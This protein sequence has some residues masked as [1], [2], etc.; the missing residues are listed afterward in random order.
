MLF[1][2][3]L[4]VIVVIEFRLLQSTHI[5]DLN[6]LPELVANEESI[7]SNIFPSNGSFGYA[8]LCAFPK[9][10]L[11]ANSSSCQCLALA[12]SILAS[13]GRYPFTVLVPRKTKIMRQY[14]HLLRQLNIG[15]YRYDDVPIPDAAKKY[16]GHK[17]SWLISYQRIHA[18]RLPFKRVLFLDNDMIVTKNI[19]E[20]FLHDTDMIGSDCTPHVM[21]PQG[22]A[23]RSRLENLSHIGSIELISPGE[24]NFQMLYDLI[25][26]GAVRN[27]KGHEVGWKWTQTDQ[28]LFPAAFQMARLDCKYQVFPDMCFTATSPPL[29][30]F[31]LDQFSIV[32]YTWTARK[33]PEFM[34]P[35]AFMS[36]LVKFTRF[37]QNWHPLPL[38]QRHSP[39]AT[40]IDQMSH[41]ELAA[42]YVGL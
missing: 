6:F 21:R 1:F 13:H 16:H 41:D 37:E 42:R 11:A 18:F 36:L 26:N 8:T 27:S 2:Q 5:V 20:I 17:L 15:I 19:D 39:V 3:L 28:T 23:H 25:Q 29:K 24:S 34:S 4:V 35:S 10:E 32:H 31:P 7:N 38:Q 30:Y 9:L 22:P 33:G 40:V 14:W 12:L